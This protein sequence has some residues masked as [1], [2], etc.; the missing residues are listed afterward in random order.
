MLAGGKQTT[1]DREEILCYSEKHDRESEKAGYQSMYSY[2]MLFKQTKEP[3][4]MTVHVYRSRNKPGRMDIEYIHGVIWGSCHVG[5][6][7]F[8]VFLDFLQQIELIL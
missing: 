6:F 7:L 8:P 5:C 3:H 1:G 4:H 2:V